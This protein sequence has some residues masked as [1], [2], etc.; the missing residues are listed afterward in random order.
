MS[1]KIRNFSRRGLGV[2]SDKGESV[3]FYNSTKP[4]DSSL[5]IATSFNGYSFLP[6]LKKGCIFKKG[7]FKR[8][9]NISKCSD[10]NINKIDKK[11]YFLIYKKFDGK[12]KI[13]NG[14]ISDNLLKWREI[15]SYFNLKE[16]GVL[17]SNFKF[18][19]Q[20]VFYFGNKS[21]KV[22]FSSDLKKWNISRKSL[23][24]ARKSSFDNNIINPAGVFFRKEGLALLYYS[25]DKKGM[26]SI[27]VALFSK[28]DPKK[29]LWRCRTPIWKQTDELKNESIRPLGLVKLRNKL[30]SYWQKE[31]G[32]FFSVFLPQVWYQGEEEK[33]KEEKKP[34]Q[35]ERS[36]KNPIIEPKSKNKWERD[37]TFNPT[38]FRKNKK[39]YVLY[40]A[41]GPDFL[42]SVGCSISSDGV[43]VE[44]R[45]GGPIY[46]ARESFEGGVNP[47][48]I[49]EAVHYMSGGGCGG[50]ED[51][52]IVEIEGRFYLTY[53]A[54]DGANPPRVAIS[55]IAVDD[56]LN[57]RWENWTKPVLISRPGV[58]DKNACI[59]PEKINGKY[60]IFHRIY[61]NILID[62]V[63][64][65]NF[66]GNTFLKNEFVVPPRPMMWDSKKV[67]VGPSPVKTDYGWLTIY[68][69][70]GRQDPGR[71][72]IG[73]MLLDL[74]D[75]TKVI[76]RSNEPIIE[77][78]EWYENEGYKA[79]VV[80]PCGAT[81]QGD[82]F[83][84]YYGGADKFSCV[85][86]SN[87]NN[88]IKE[89]ISSNKPK[90]K[91]VVLA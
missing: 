58:V 82:D 21:I 48:K 89:L 11:K 51:A 56:F 59:L 14:A 26:Y 75:P 33:E 17:V 4:S 15:G 52:R 64:S 24:K 10:F 66:D 63:D 20:Y 53:V 54:Y 16:S 18:D 83:F 25:L 44:E 2:F 12:Q 61:P 34:L 32:E 87:L 68:Q 23:L 86:Y 19:D 73:A 81:V 45:L 70:V 72:K 43:N 29:L 80:Y 88:F 40:R 38:A 28:N 37:A 41:L 6:S 42:S 78:V 85:A 69:S 71:Y 8:K 47:V 62:F 50:C 65:L 90:M 79:G 74:K 49:K 5:K 67:G 76:C 27:G 36:K 9:L 57:N 22:A 13:L 30:V 84:V 35:M 91:K 77:P 55:S 1:Q 46:K 60:V 3:V 31:D 7:I 39:T